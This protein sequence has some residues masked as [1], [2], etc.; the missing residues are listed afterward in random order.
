MA[1]TAARL[2]EPP[3][4]SGGLDCQIM[5]PERREMPLLAPCTENNSA[6]DCACDNAMG[7]GRAT[8][9]PCTFNYGDQP[10]VH[11]SGGGT[12]PFGVPTLSL[13]LPREEVPSLRRLSNF[14][15]WVRSCAD[16]T[17]SLTWVAAG[18]E[19]VSPEAFV[20][21]ELTTDSTD[22][23]MTL[24]A[25]LLFNADIAG[26]PDWSVRVRRDPPL[27]TRLFGKCVFD[28]AEQASAF[29]T[30]AQ[31]GQWKALAA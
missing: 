26:R 8:F 15:A 20:P 31:L 29:W 30:A 11:M 13:N 10:C 22:T 5:C 23:Q 27:A 1:A 3:S 19:Q 9:R 14:D 2:C 16:D 28:A 4:E 7:R 21:W 25:P 17:M 24:R 12:G 18:G 6:R